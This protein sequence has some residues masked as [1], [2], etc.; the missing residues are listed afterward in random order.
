M[1]RVAAPSGS[2]PRGFMTQSLLAFSIALS[3]LRPLDAAS[4]TIYAAA[5]SPLIAPVSTATF[6]P[7]FEIPTLPGANSFVISPLGD[8]AYFVVG[9]TGFVETS[10][11]IAAVSLVTGKILH[12]Y[13]TQYAL[14]GAIAV[15]PNESQLYAGTCILEDPFPFCATGFVEIFDIASEQELAVLTM[16]G[17][18]MNGFAVAPDGANVYVTHSPCSDC[19]DSPST[20]IPSGSVTA[21]DVATLQAGAS[22]VPPAE[23]EAMVIRGDGETGYV[24]AIPA[25]YTVSLP[26]MVQEATI[27]LPAGFYPLRTAVS[28]NGATLA[29]AGTVNH[30]PELLIIN[31]A[32]GAITQTLPGVSASN[33]L[34]MTPDGSTA[35]FVDSSGLESL[36]VQTGSINTQIPAAA[37]PVSS[38]ILPPNGEEIYL[39][40]SQ[41]TEIMRLP[42]LSTRPVFFNIGQPS[43]WLA[44]SPNGQTLYSASSTGIAAVSTTTGAVVSTMLQGTNTA[45]IAASPDGSKLY[46]VSLPNPDFLVVNASTGAVENTI[47]LPPCGSSP[48]S[49]SIA[50]VPGG[51]YAFLKVNAAY[52]AACGDIIPIDLTTLTVESGIPGAYCTVGFIG[53]REESRIGRQHFGYASKLSDVLLQRRYQPCGIGRTLLA[54]FAVRN[55]LIFGLLDFDQFAEL[56]RLTGFSL[57]DH[58]GVRLKDTDQLSLRVRVAAPESLACLAHHLLH[59][60]NHF[61]QLFFGLA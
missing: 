39:V 37:E 9:P 44:V 19:G 2:I 25:I 60:R 35:Y 4:S 29:V 16:N 15:L 58:F 31:P 53:R 41:S 49:A 20:S 3:L 45:A 46:V 24:Q 48:E 14:Q 27:V 12:T 30:A 51:G 21:I 1:R 57:A 10:Y 42:E 52:Q 43:D 5:S 23:P 26:E 11:E 36:N 55:D 28:A 6:M 13:Q 33:S 18:Q 47:S 40:L 22:Y 59:A 32:S 17:D 7:S 34:S 54:N 56:I 38:F 61:V 50:L 8:T